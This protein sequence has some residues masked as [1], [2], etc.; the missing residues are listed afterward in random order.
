MAS[1]TYLRERNVH[2]TDGTI[3][4]EPIEEK[5]YWPLMTCRNFERKFPDNVVKIDPYDQQSQG[6]PSPKSF[7]RDK[8]YSKSAQSRAKPST[9]KLTT[10]A[11]A[12]TSGLTTEALIT[13]E[14]KKA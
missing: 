2:H 14:A 11:P 3:T 4:Q 8:F 7:S 5:R 1:I 10:P 13:E 9:K 12:S 6:R